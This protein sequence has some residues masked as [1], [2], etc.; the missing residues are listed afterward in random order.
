MRL[1]AQYPWVHVCVR[2]VDMCITALMFCRVNWILCRRTVN[3]EY[4]QDANDWC[5]YIVTTVGLGVP[6]GLMEKKKKREKESC[7]KEQEGGGNDFYPGT[8]GES[9]RGL[10]LEWFWIF[11]F[12]F[13]GR[14][15]YTLISK[16]I[17]L[18]LGG[19][20]KKQGARL[21]PAS[22]CGAAVL[23]FVGS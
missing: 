13:F 18:N 23:V 7:R 20:Q 16:L 4:V 12:F 8:Y 22:H 6:G 10:R 15:V 1:S 14:A 2:P 17:S 5:D 3:L 11:F 19:R 21:D 9:F